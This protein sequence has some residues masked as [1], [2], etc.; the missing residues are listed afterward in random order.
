MGPQAPLASGYGGGGHSGPAL[1]RAIP[2]L[3]PIPV[4]PCLRLSGAS[5]RHAEESRRVGPRNRLM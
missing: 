5:K 1:T 3:G 2:S 4:G